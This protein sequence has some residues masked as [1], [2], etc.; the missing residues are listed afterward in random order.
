MKR[1]F[2]ILAAALIIFGAASCKKSSKGDP[3][4]PKTT[5]AIAV[6]DIT[7]GNCSFTISPS[8]NTVEYMLVFMKKADLG[9]DLV[10]T[11]KDYLASDQYTY[12][13]YKTDGCITKDQTIRTETPYGLSA[14]TQ[15]VLVVFQIDKDLNISGNVTASEPFYTLPEN[16]FDLGLP[17]GTIWNFYNV[18]N[19]NHTG[20][21][22]T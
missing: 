7:D 20:G 9:S 22:W 14:N 2:S 4:A 5:F 15:Y 18:K 21:L 12:E 13:K 16:Y 6:S 17:S 19:P 3:E 1:I 10:K 8:D 11:M